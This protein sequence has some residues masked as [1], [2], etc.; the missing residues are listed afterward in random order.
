MTKEE[1]IA[2]VKDLIAAP[3]CYAGLKEKAEAY[4]NAVG[5]AHEKEA[6]KT[7]EKELSGDVQ[8][9]DTVLAFFKSDAAGGIFGKETAEKMAAHAEDIKG[10]GAKFCDCPACSA[11]KDILDHKD[12]LLG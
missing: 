1:M 7:L 11:G 4:L 9:I 3:S 10:K 5:T 6:A 8:S 2:R 12:V